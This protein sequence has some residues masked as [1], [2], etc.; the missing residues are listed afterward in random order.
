[1]NT[2][3]LP[4]LEIYEIPGIIHYN[5]CISMARDKIATSIARKLNLA[6]K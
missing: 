4:Y 1:M 3:P 5:S 2:I 6:G